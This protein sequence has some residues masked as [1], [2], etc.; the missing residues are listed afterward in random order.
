MARAVEEH[1]GG[2]A[3]EHDLAQADGGDLEVRDRRA[4][5]Q[6]LVVVVHR[7]DGATPLARAERKLSNSA[8]CAARSWKP[9]STTNWSRSDPQI[10]ARSTNTPRASWARG[11]SGGSGTSGSR[12]G[13]RGTS[14]SERDRRLRSCPGAVDDLRTLA[15]EHGHPA[16]DEQGDGP[17]HHRD[18]RA[19]GVGQLAGGRDRRRGRRRPAAEDARRRRSSWCRLRWSWSSHRPV[20]VVVPRPP[21]VVVVPR[22]PSSWS[23]HRRS[24]WSWL[25][26]PRPGPSRFGRGPA[27][28]GVGR[29]RHRAGVVRVDELAAVLVHAMPTR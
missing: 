23:S 12:R 8:C 3:L 5:T 7:G 19:T 27:A 28:A 20:V 29:H 13:P 1:A 2:G 16:E 9:E 25:P 18:R 22:R 17:D 6:R 26:P 15:E 24:S 21:V 14:A 11:V 10:T 4:R